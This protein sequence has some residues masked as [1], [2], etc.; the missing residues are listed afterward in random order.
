MVFES[1][2][3][4][5]SHVKRRYSLSTFCAL[6]PRRRRIF[7]VGNMIR[8]LPVPRQACS[9]VRIVYIPEQSHLNQKAN[10]VH[11][12]IRRLSPLPSRFFILVGDDK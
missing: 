11:G 2:K 1:S 4:Y 6:Q 5:D 8:L 7:P 12:T 3:I 10:P 9:C